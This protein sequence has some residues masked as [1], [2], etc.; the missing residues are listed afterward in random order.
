MKK[1]GEASSSR[2]D[3]GKGA[4]RLPLGEFADVVITGAFE[5]DLEARLA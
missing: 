1:S 3:Y 2:G 5:Y 4:A